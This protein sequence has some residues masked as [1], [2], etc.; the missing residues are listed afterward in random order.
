MSLKNHKEQKAEKITRFS[1]LQFVFVENI[2]LQSFVTEA[3][4]QIT[5]MKS[6][7]SKT[8]EVRYVTKFKN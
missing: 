6:I 7:I 4:L 1:Y 2:A 5:S 8:L 3:N